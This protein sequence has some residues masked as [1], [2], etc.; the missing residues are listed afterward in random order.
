MVI[1]SHAHLEMLK[2]DMQNI[3]DNMQQD[4]LEKIVT[5][6]TSSKDSKVAVKIAEKNKNVYAAVGLYPEYV[7]DI[8]EKDLEII[9]NLAS[10]PKVVAVGEI[11]LD[12]HRENPNKEGQK[13]LLIKQ[14]KIAKKH[15]LPLVI[16]TRS[17]KEDTYSVL[18]EYKEDIVFPSVMHCFSE[19]R[20][21]AL[22][23]VELGF[24]ISFAGNITFKK[25][26]RSFLKDIPLD[27]FL[28]ETVG[29][30]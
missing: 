10:H 30:D 12:Y 22:K 5:I 18:K 17:A 1:D 27:R 13:Q 4:G 3:I 26:D 24:C 23:F 14:I 15:G 21:Y 20:E 8:T 7:D 11:G 19:D 25:S 28:V 9:D 2:G 29:Y 16:H 6:G